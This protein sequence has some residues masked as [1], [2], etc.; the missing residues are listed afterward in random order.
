M[1]LQHFL[2][3]CM[4]EKDTYTY[5]LV[6]ILKFRA[7]AT[8]DQRAYT[9]LTDGENQEE[10]ITYRELDRQ[11]KVVAANLQEMQAKGE[12]ALM[13]YP[14]SL[15]FIISLWG[16]FYAGVIAVPA[17]PPRKNRSLLR[18]RS[19]VADSGAKIILST[20]Q[21]YENVR[22]NFADDKDL[23]RM[24][25]LETDLLTDSSG[26][27]FESLPISPEEIALLQ[28][29]SGSTGLPKG[30]M[31]SHLNIMRNSECL[32]H[33]FEL[34]TSSV[35]VSW[36]PT[37]HDMGL[38]L[39]AIQPVY[40]GFPGVLLPP[41]S[42]LQKPVRWLRAITKYKGTIG[43]GPNFGYDLCVDKISEEERASLD[44]S[45]MKSLYNGA[46]PIRQATLERFIS[47]FKPYGFKPQAFYPCY[48][49][50]ETTLIISGVRVEDKPYCLAVNTE[51]LEGNM[52]IEASTGDAKSYSLVS[53][54]RTW[55]DTRVKIVNP[56]TL[57]E[58]RDDEVGEIWVSGSSV[59]KGYYNN[60]PETKR[61]FHA[62][63]KGPVDG[64]YLRTGDL[65]FFYNEQLFISGRLK[66]IIIIYGRNYYPQ[67]IE[68][69]IEDNVQELR[70][71]CSAAFPC[72]INNEERLV[73]V[74]EVERTC[75]RG[76]GVEK[77][78]DAIRTVVS[79]ELE[80]QVYA[81]QLLRTASI[82][83]TSSGKIQRRACKQGF[84]DG[85]LNVVGTSVFDHKDQVMI[86]HDS[87]SH[88]S[89]QA[90]LMSW[91]STK[92]N[93]A[94]EIID[95]EKPVTAY[96]L[97]SMKAI[98][99]QQHFLDT[100]GVDFPPYLFFEK[101]SISGLAEKAWGLIDESRNSS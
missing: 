25:W 32:R 1:S 37:F 34:S 4:T 93:I 91:I 60:R 48:G 76:L 36:L 15:A 19:I 86:E 59:A 52:I 40:T 84:L 83:K 3:N 67:D 21:I 90:W 13:L 16:C 38:I 14:P 44:L 2:N 45:S 10:H 27:K 58:C 30:V 99:L 41:V 51:G 8:P 94:I 85:S 98:E 62:F 18:I 79:E 12:R 11:A 97:N 43:G 9:Y 26:L 29:T 23:E 81:I 35:S 53:I 49:M 31:V 20:Q 47:T 39:G 56:E 24:K 70:P 80:L 72:D 7:S 33:S 68:F 78:C 66:D 95:P 63:T 77:V 101:I 69:I 87:F 82:P 73:I 75:L 61:S 64:P 17:Y 5:T 96:G 92:F 42:F 22:K 28:Y 71:N 57:R 50:S 55:L 46:E 54:G 6:D 65:G 74:A 88:A 89:V 100:F